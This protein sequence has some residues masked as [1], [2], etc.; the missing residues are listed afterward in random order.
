[1]TSRDIYAADQAKGWRP[2]G[3]LVPFLGLAFVALTVVG[4]TSVLQYAHLVDANESPVGL[5]GFAAFLLLPFTALGLAVLAWVRFV[6]RR[7]LA[8]IGLAA[9]HGTRTFLLG[10]LTAVAMVS[11]IVAGIWIV[12]GFRA[13]Y[14]APAFHSPAGLGGIAVL[15]A[16]FALQSSVEEILFR[17]W[18][19]SAIAAK[20]G[21]AIAIVLSSLV[22]TVM[23][24]DPHAGVIFTVNVFLFAVFACCWAIRTGNVWGV[25]GWHA[26]W[27][28]LLATGFELRVTSLDAHL[29]ALLVQMIPRGPD[30]LTGGAE[31]PE[32][33]IVCSL[34]LA[35][36][37]AFVGLRPTRK[38]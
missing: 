27:N 19:L 12:G 7:P 35:G 11:S 24:Y 21:V 29:P 25:M 28:W 5:I 18:M 26:G 8:T 16:C 13:G 4:L 23:H 6:E 2:W 10:H 32:G 3:A 37:L 30:Y 22:F 15:L 31:G 34:A 14:Y 36:G 20:F 17:G 38:N 33:S 9:Q 1:M